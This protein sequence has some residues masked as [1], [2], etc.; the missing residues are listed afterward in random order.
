[1]GKQSEAAAAS[2]GGYSMG[3]QSEA[4]AMGQD[5]P[6]ADAGKHRHYLPQRPPGF[7]VQGL[8]S[9]V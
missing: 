4:A 8:G 5:I 1:M 6:V 7:M 3:K 9:R 2:V